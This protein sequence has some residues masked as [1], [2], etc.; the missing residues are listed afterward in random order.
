M[1]DWAGSSGCKIRPYRNAT[2]PKIVS[3]EESTA[4]SSAVIARGDVVAFDTVVA[5]AAQRILRAPS[6]GGTGTNLLQISVTSLI[7]VAVDQ[8][9]SDGSTTGLNAN[10]VGLSRN[11]H[12]AVVAATPG[13]EFIG[14]ASTMAP[15]SSAANRELVGRQVPLVYDRTHHSFFVATA[16]ATAALAAVNITQVPE[17]AL[18]D[19]GAYPVIFTFLSSNISPVVP[20]VQ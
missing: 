20:G 13:Q 11:R 9:T 17:Y 10:G 7:G 1:A 15:A 2:V 16:N 6:S 18:G 14:Y 5:T 4:A 3:F 8:S 19:S 12:I